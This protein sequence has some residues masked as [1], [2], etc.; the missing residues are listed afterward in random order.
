[1]PLWYPQLFLTQAL[2]AA[3]GRNLIR[4]HQ[5]GVSPVGAG[6]GKERCEPTTDVSRLRE[7]QESLACFLFL[8]ICLEW[9]VTMFSASV[10]RGCSIPPVA[11]LALVNPRD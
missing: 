7:D 10:K 8:A 6:P 5:T 3:C 2:R 4:S 9:D 1:M 11:C